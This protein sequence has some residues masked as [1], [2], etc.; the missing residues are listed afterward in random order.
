VRPLYDRE[1]ATE[2]VL[3]DEQAK[4]Q[5]VL[6]KA[7]NETKAWQERFTKTIKALRVRRPWS[8]PSFCTFSALIHLSTAG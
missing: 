3:A 6:K 7:H 2:K 1:A 4:G 5:E 8:C